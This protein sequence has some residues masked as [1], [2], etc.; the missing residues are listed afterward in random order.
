[1][2]MREAKGDRAASLFVLRAAASLLAAWFV[3]GVSTRARADWWSENVEFHGKLQSS[4]YF[5]D[6]SLNKDFKMDQWWNELQLKTDIKLLTDESTQIT[7]HTIIMPTYDLA[8]DA[9]PNLYGR[10]VSDGG[11]GSQNANI[12]RDAMSGIRYPNL[13]PPGSATPTFVPGPG[14]CIKGLFCYVNQD[15]SFLFTGVKNPQEVIDNVIFFGIL[16]SQVRTR[17]ASLQGKLGGN[18]SMQA[19]QF[20]SGLDALTGGHPNFEATYANGVAAGG[21]FKPLHSFGGPATANYLGYVIGDRGSFDSQFP[22]GINQTEGQTKTHCFDSAHPWCWL[23]E[24][25]FESHTSW[26]M[27]ETSLRVGKQ[28]IVWGKTDAFRLQDIVNPID[29]GYHNVFPSLDERRIPTLSADL[30]HSFGNVGPL[31]DVSL[32]LVWVFDKFMPVQVGQCGDFWAFTAACEARAD[33]GAHGL[34]DVSA[35]R[36]DQRKWSFHNTEPGFRFEFRTPEPSI[37]FSLSGFW[38]IQDAGVARFENPYSTNNPNPA[39]MMFL[40]AI[41]P[42]LDSLIPAFNPYDKASVQAASNAALGFWQGVFGPACDAQPTQKARLACFSNPAGP[43]ILGWIWSSSQGVVEYPRTF[44]LGGSMDYQIPNID[45]VLRLEASYDFN[46]AIEDTNRLDGIGHSDVVAAAVGLDRSFFI[47]FLNKDR[48]AFVSGQTFMQHIMNFDGNQKVGMTD[49]E[50]SVISTLFMQNYWRGDSIVLTNFFAYDW[51]AHAWVTGPSLKWI[52][53]ESIYFEGGVNLLQGRG[54]EHN[55][56]DICAGGGFNCL[57][58]PTTWQ[59]GNWQIINAG[60]QRYS[61]SPFWSMES[62]ADRQMKKKDEV[63]VGVTYQF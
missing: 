48:T 43:Q 58:D 56:R 16:G 41:S 2:A 49:Y 55:I 30:V 4:V 18:S 42:G 57:G 53:N 40:Q 24:F 62:F 29:F 54:H 31:Q 63:W 50:W 61:Q 15:T 59:A 3:F 46:R 28:Q 26:D 25:Y 32:E 10:D 39:M 12:A 47:P 17:S 33:V 21:N 44:T 52:L 51:S 22:A 13:V 60:L 27:G 11:L 37:S 45:T 38:G 36:V 8:Y 19:F 35:A 7:F 9:Y 23:R 34:L 6:P 14:A 1:M 20:A 5:A